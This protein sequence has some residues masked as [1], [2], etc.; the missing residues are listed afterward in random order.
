[1]YMAPEIVRGQTYDN[2]CDVWALGVIT[3]MILTGRPPF[4]NYRK[5]GNKWTL[6]YTPDISLLRRYF[7]QGR[8]ASGFI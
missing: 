6:N 2:R 7:K 4:T 5:E 1:M 8:L 3:Y